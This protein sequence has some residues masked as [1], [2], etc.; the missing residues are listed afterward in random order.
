MQ[1]ILLANFFSDKF[2]YIFV[3]PSFALKGLFL[4]F[5]ADFVCS[6]VIDIQLYTI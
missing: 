3:V 6:M 4:L 1:L 2:P 5:F